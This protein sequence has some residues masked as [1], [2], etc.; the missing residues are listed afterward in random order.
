[1]K[2]LTKISRFTPLSLKQGSI[3]LTHGNAPQDTRD[4]SGDDD[5]GV[6]D[7]LIALCYGID[8]EVGRTGQQYATVHTK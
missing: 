6:D 4:E 3:I 7:R 8:E 2:T 1:M 5:L